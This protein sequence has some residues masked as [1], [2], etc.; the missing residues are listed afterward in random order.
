MQ[1]NELEVQDMPSLIS[2]AQK[3]MAVEECDATMLN[4]NTIARIKKFISLFYFLQKIDSC[5]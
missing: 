5:I 1:N 4:S 2:P 3:A